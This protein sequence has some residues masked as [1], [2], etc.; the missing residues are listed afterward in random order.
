MSDP[1][2]E[3]QKRYYC[4]VWSVINGIRHA[5]GGDSSAMTFFIHS[6]YLSTLVYSPGKSFEPH[7]TPVDTIPTKVYISSPVFA[8]VPSRTSGPPESPCKFEKKKIKSYFHI[9]DE[10]NGYGHKI[11]EGY[12][13]PWSG[14]CWWKQAWKNKQTAYVYSSLATRLTLLDPAH[15]CNLLKKKKEMRP[16]REKGCMRTDIGKN[17]LT[18]KCWRTEQ[19]DMKWRLFRSSRDAH[20][21][22]IG[23]ARQS[24]EQWYEVSSLLI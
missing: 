24:G 1:P 23:S 22:A 15:R 11:K 4:A 7:R 13:L 16:P 21:I 9:L 18:V 5:I 8:L 14:S 20:R 12:K 2:C 6:R 10:S 17:S 19:F 3:E